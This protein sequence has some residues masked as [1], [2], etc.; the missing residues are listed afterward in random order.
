MAN[1][2]AETT[3]ASGASLSLS[4]NAYI[5]SSGNWVYRTGGK[6][7][8][9]YQYNGDIGFRSAASGS[10]GGT[11]SWKE[12][13]TIGHDQNIYIWGNETGNNRGILYN[14]PSY[15]GIYGSSNGSVHRE[16]RLHSAG[17]STSERMRIT[18]SDVQVL[19]TSGKMIDCRTSATTGNCWIALSESDGTNKGYF[20][21]GS[22]SN[23]QLYIVQQENADITIYNGS[24]S[25]WYYKTD[26][27]YNSATNGGINV[28]GGGVHHDNDAV[29]Y[30]DKTNN[31]D[32]CV[33]VNTGGNDYGIYSRVGNTA[34]YGIGVYDHTNSTWRFRVQGNGSIY[35]QNTS[36]SSI[37]DRRL[38]E[39]IVDANSQWNDI[40]ALR[41]RNF[42]WKNDTDTAPKL[43][44][45]S[46]EV[47]SV[48][49]NLIDPIAQT[50]EDIENGVTDP[51][52]KGVKYSIVWMKAVKALQEAQARIETLEAKVA[53]LESS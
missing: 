47:E 7:T 18:S 45:I 34:A 48:S 8:N 12:R 39:N 43:G 1:L 32:W 28:Y 49:P 9:I 42:T 22:S 5:N 31:A 16:L 15:F 53:A 11:I 52:Y 40:K 24:A 19:N 29:F 3:A 51:E 20:G 50:K 25:R 26:G 2:Y 44:L 41:F 33:A 37:S 36:I 6:S 10:A 21:Y 27:Q 13:L 23:E 35:A 14:G 17:G 38:K 4:N 30:A 46:D